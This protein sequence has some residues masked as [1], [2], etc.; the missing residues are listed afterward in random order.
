LKYL[1]IDRYHK[2]TDEV[3]LI[4]FIELSREKGVKFWRHKSGQMANEDL[5]LPDKVYYFEFGVNYPVLYRK[6]DGIK[7]DQ[8][9]NCPSQL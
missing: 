3:N 7:L 8:G 6:S 2:I 1:C 9:N 4:F 5:F